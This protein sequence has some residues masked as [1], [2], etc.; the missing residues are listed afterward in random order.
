MSPRR[1]LSLLCVAVSATGLVGCGG[2]TLSFDPVASA[3]TKTA[4]SE[5]GRVAFTATMDMDG[6]GGMAFSGS[7]VF[8]GRSHSGTLNM[9]FR[10]PADARAQLGGVDPTMQMIMDGRSGLV[11]YMRSPLFARVAGD[12]WIKFDMGKFAQKQGVDLNALMNAN[13]ADPSQTLAMLKASADAHQVGYDHIRGVFTTHYELDI[14][15]ARLAK[16]NKN[17]RKMVDTVREVTGTTSYPAEAWVDDAGRV[18]RMK[19]DMSFN[20]PAGG[21]FT[22]SMTED[23]FA[24]G[25]KVVVRPPAAGRVLDASALVSQGG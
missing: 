12:R 1:V 9:R 14:D 23:L 5:S 4:T 15:L 10:L 25:T 8:D 22:L 6:I 13:Q 21:A 19:I 16:E 7:G 11:M 3:A 2:D 17:L 24:F 18:R 20:S